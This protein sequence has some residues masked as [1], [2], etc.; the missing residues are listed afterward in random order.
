MSLPD[1]DCGGH[2]STVNLLS[3]SRNKSEDGHTVHNTQVGCG[4]LMMRSFIYN[5]QQFTPPAAAA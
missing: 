1:G 5:L 2:W 3:R 4:I